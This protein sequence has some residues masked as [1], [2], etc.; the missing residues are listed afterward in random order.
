[1]SRT[2]CEVAVCGSVKT[3]VGYWK[4]NG[5]ESATGGILCL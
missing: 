1:M 3:F 2:L 5:K 4:R